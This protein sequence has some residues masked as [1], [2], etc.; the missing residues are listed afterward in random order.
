MTGDEAERPGCDERPGDVV[1]LL[2][3]RERR[4]DRVALLQQDDEPR[5]R[6]HDRQEPV[7]RDALGGDRRRQAIEVD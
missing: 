7:R 6:R 4:Q 2:T 5:Q 3:E 1:A